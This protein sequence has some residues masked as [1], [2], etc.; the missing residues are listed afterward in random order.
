M[1]RQQNV[2]IT[3]TERL[4]QAVE[5]M[6]KLEELPHDN[7]PTSLSKAEIDA[8]EKI[9]TLMQYQPDRKRFR[10][11]LLWK[12][13]QSVSNNYS[14]AHARL[15]GLMRKLRKNDELKH[16]YVDAMQD[17]MNL[18]VVELVHDDDPKDMSRRDLN[19][20]PHRAVYDPTRTSTK[21]RI[22]FDGS[23]RTPSGFSLNQ[24][25]G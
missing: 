14:S 25:L 4:A 23:A 13:E 7:S 18:G 10:T 12:D 17:Y 24:C 11:G 22:V 2:Y 15:E 1:I 16:A 3:S 8:V 19:Y 5:K 6:W 20:L 21:C 9:N